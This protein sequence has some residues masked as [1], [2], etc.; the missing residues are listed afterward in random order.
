MLSEKQ[1]WQL[2]SLKKVKD[3]TLE[4]VFIIF[5]CLHS[6]N[7]KGVELVQ[8]QKL[9]ISKNSV[10]P[11]IFTKLEQMQEMVCFQLG[12]VKIKVKVCY[13]EHLL[14]ML[15]IEWLGARLT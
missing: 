2:S 4:T 9:T 8:G 10:F 13:Y 14:A 6:I 11:K 1:V 12:A 3:E 15:I 7:S 5:S